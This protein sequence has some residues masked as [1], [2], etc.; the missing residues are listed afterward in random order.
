MEVLKAE[1]AVTLPVSS[2]ITDNIEQTSITSLN[3]KHDVEEEEP[4]PSGIYQ[5]DN[6]D[7]EM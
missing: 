7:N 6:T 3:I 4:G 1:R 5:D 2:E